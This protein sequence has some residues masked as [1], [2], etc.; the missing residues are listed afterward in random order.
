MSPRPCNCPCIKTKM[1][2]RAESGK[3]RMGSQGEG[4]HD[5]GSSTTGPNELPK[6]G[7]RM[8]NQGWKTPKIDKP[9]GGSRGLMTT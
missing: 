7:T 8:W 1:A 2:H 3:E 6:C 9:D 4:L 5:E